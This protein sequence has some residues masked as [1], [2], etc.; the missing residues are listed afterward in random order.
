MFFDNKLERT[1]WSISYRSP[2]LQPKYTTTMLPDSEAIYFLLEASFVTGVILDVD[3]GH[4]I[5]QYADKRKDP[6]RK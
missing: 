3:G 2:R 1:V 5:R 6:M 4:H